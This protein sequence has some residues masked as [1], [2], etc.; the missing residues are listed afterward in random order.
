MESKDNNLFFYPGIKLG[1]LSLSF[2]EKDIIKILGNP[3][4]QNIDRFNDFEYAVHLYYWD[5]G[6]YP[7]IYYKNES[8]EYLHIHSGDIIL[9]NVKF[10]TL[11]KSEVL[12]LIKNYHFKNKLQYSCE[13][14]YDED[15]DEECYYFEKIGLTIWF[16][17]DLMSNVCVQ[18]K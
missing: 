15:V 18:R 9:D 16:E 12:S 17:K 1:K 14:A 7:S 10:S 3:E 6:I 4:E 11:K 5:L 2:Q 13:D 8:F